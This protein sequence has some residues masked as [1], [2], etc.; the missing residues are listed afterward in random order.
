MKLSKFLCLCV[1]IAALAVPMHTSP[2]AAYTLQEA[3]KETEKLLSRLA[4]KQFD[5]LANEMERH[6]LFGTVN[7][8]LWQQVVTTVSKAYVMVGENEPIYGFAKLGQ[9]KIGDRLVSNRYAI[10]NSKLPILFEFWLYKPGKDWQFLNVNMV[11]GTD[12]KPVLQK[13]FDGA[14]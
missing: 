8:G 11:F 12:S 5:G 3:E 4:N 1:V 6:E 9:K 7:P 13:W 10:L 14:D 2:A